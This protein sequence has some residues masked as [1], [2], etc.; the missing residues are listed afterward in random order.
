MKHSRD[1]TNQTRFLPVAACS[2]AP[3]HQDRSLEHVT[4]YSFQFSNSATVNLV[5]MSTKRGALV[6][7]LGHKMGQSFELID[8][9]AWLVNLR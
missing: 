5:K 3:G 6:H 2:A 9:L 4:C 7:C 8:T 1:I